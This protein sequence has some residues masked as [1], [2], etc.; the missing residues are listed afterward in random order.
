MLSIVNVIWNSWS[1]TDSI[2]DTG[3]TRADNNQIAKF[4]FHL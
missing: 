4:E 2:I 1:T 3:D